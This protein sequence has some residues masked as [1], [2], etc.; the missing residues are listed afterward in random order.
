VFMVET[1]ES[2]TTPQHIFGGAPGS[3]ARGATSMLSM[4]IGTGRP[5]PAAAR[6]VPQS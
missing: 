6:T 2:P 3:L 4:T 1:A 5:L